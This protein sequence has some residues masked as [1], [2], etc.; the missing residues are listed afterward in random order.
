MLEVSTQQALGLEVRC[1]HLRKPLS[2]RQA[3]Q[4]WL[5]RFMSECL[6]CEVV[7]RDLT[8]KPLAS[9]KAAW[10]AVGGRASS[11]ARPTEPRQF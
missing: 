8:L 5:Q 3:A 6:R 11:R 10:F 4:W 1:R 9:A 2:R 7:V